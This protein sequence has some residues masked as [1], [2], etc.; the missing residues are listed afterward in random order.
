MFQTASHKVNQ[1]KKITCIL[2]ITWFGLLAPRE[3]AAQPVTFTGTE[4][5]GKPT[6]NSVTV[7]IIPDANIQLYFEYG[8]SSGGPYTAQTDIT[9]ASAGQPHE[10][11]IDGLEAD[12]RYY[13]RMQYS[14]D[15]GLTWEIRN[16][17]TFHTQRSSG[18]TFKFTIITDSHAMYD[19]S[20]RNAVVNVI[21]DQPD[22]HFDL[23][24]TYMVD[25]TTTQTAVNNA[26][27]AQ[28]DPLYMGGIGH[29]SPIFLASGNHEN[30]EGWNFD[31]TPFSIALA[32]VKA[33][34][35]YYPTPVPDGF[36]TGNTDPLAGIDPGTYGDQYREDY[37]AWEWGDALFVVFDPFQYTMQNPYGASAGEGGDDPATGDRWNWT[38]GQQQYNWF[39]QTLENSSAR[40]KFIFAHHMLGGTQNYVRGGAVPAHMFEW[41]GYNAD[42]TTWG[43]TTQRPDWGDNPVHQLMIDNG[44]SAFFHGHDH[45]YAYEVRDGI[46]YQ[47]IPKPSLG[48]EF[49]YYKES[50]PYTEKVL[51]GPGSLCVTVTPEVV[52]VEYISSSSST[53]SVSHTYNILPNTSAATHDLTMVVD[54]EG[55]GTTTPTVGVHTYNE[56]SVVN[57]TADPSAG[58]AFDHWTGDV[59]NVSSASTTVT[60]DADKTVTASFVPAKA[61]DIN[62]DKSANSTDALIILLCDAGIDISQFCPCNCGDVNGDGVINSTDALIILLYDAGMSVPYAVGEGDC[63][64]GVTPCAGCSAGK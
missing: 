37:Y 26:Y 48:L 46:V 22:F 8:T 2:L 11:V 57:I 14:T 21:N 20:Y 30:E 18:S 16:E 54:P 31:D 55:T 56:N 49:N 63:P 13:Y 62:G 47:C 17:Y 44:V 58:Y 1:I 6:D 59:A 52:T 40:Y 32:S 3:L 28:R 41:G 4:L 7:N 9:S 35:L 29:S 25:N 10:T 60:I 23:G 12:T 27:L 5:L 50:D 36:Y 61:G 34:K 39:K 24:D 51:T 15:G 64:S 38:M 53:R 42:G 33:R 19:A 45:Q 43:Y